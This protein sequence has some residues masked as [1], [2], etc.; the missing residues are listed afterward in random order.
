M[1]DACECKLPDAYYYLAVN[2]GGWKCVCC[3]N[4]VA[5]DPPGYSPKL[6]REEIWRK[7]SGILNDLHMLNVVYISNGTMGDMLTGTVADICV[8]KGHYD[9]YTIASE[10]LGQ[11]TKS[12]AE[13]WAKKAKEV[14]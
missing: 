10:I 13:F 5:G 9:Q 6:D 8:K 11:L 14:L 7:V 3:S 12:H 4:P 1:A 2:E